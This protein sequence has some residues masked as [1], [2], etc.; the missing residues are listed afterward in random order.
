VLAYRFSS[1]NPIG[2]MLDARI[3]GAIDRGMGLGLYG[4]PGLVPSD[5]RGA[6]IGVDVPT[7]GFALALYALAHSLGVDRADYE[8]VALGSTP[9]RLEAL[10]AGRCDATMLNAGNELMAEAAGCLRL[11]GVTDSYTPYLGTVVAVVG[12]RRLDAAR[13]L[14]QAMSATC[15][16][17]VRGSLDTE[18]AEAAR[19][20]LGLDDVLAKRYVQRL[21]DHDDGLITDGVAD[22]ASLATLVRLRSRW[23][24][25][26]VDGRDV[27]ETALARG[28]GLVDAG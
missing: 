21:R 2:T 11:A 28:S 23:L 3:V 26:T 4:R 16:S 25:E 6:S 13:R 8:V 27:M 7:S 22:V 1:H 24:P 15:E 14:A 10:L 19:R 9:Q 18:A 17:V 12:E 5:L 20:R